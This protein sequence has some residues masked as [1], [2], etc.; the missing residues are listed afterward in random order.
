MEDENDLRKK[1]PFKE[2]L[3]KST[4][5]ITIFGV[6]N[7]L[8]IYS[9][10]INN[11]NIVQFLLPAFFA[12]SLLVWFELILFAID[13]N[14]GSKKYELFYFLA[15]SI[16][17]GFLWYFVLIF[18]TLLSLLAFYGLFILLLYGIFKILLLILTKW[19][20]NYKSKTRRN[21]LALMLIISSIISGLILL[22]LLNLFEPWL[23][24][25]FKTIKDLPINR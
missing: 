24:E 14:N 6:L 25:V 23:K 20:I 19:L 21:L 18:K 3:D 10:T 1:I 4:N 15:C 17:L 22:F 9:S 7:A 16:E 13:S 5:L 11:K 8:L 12:L 2:F